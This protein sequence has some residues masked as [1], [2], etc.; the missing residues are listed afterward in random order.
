LEKREGK[1]TLGI[2]RLGC[3]DNIRMDLRDIGWDGMDWVDVAQ[4]REQ[5]MAVVNTVIN[6]RVP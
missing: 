5:W 2:P 3:V 4:D 1:G 6:L